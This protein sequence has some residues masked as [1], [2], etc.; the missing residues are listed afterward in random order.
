[1]CRGHCDENKGFTI[2][3][4]SQFHLFV[5]R[6]GREEIML[7]L[8]VI[9]TTL[10]KITMSLLTFWSG[11]ALTFDGPKT[12]ISKGG[13]CMDMNKMEVQ[14]WSQYC[15]YFYNLIT[16]GFEN[17]QGLNPGKLGGYKDWDQSPSALLA[18][19]HILAFPCRPNLLTLAGTPL[20]QF[21]P[22]LIH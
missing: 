18:P 5:S 4:I 13:H 22:H 14:I 15:Q 21:L 9:L 12:H 7:S 6:E 8:P 1:M 16:S 17:E 2:Y 20:K 3:R 19:Y 10:E 11:H